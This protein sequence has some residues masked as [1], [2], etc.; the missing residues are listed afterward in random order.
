MAQNKLGELG[1]ELHKTWNNEGL[2]TEEKDVLQNKYE[3]L[4]ESAAE[5][6]SSNMGSVPRNIIERIEFIKNKRKTSGPVG[7]MVSGMST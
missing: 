4:V 7:K 6:C 3:Q 5:N 1:K 2:S